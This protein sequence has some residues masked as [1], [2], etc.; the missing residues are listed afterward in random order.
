[1]IR[2]T[3]R[4]SRLERR[5]ASVGYAPSA[6]PRVNRGRGRGESREKA[7]S[8]HGRTYGVDAI[9]GAFRFRIHSACGSS[10]GVRDFR[11]SFR[12]VGIPR[13]N[14]ER[15]TTLVGEDEEKGTTTPKVRGRNADGRVGTYVAA[16]TCLSPCTYTLLLVTMCTSR[17]QVLPVLVSLFLP[18]SLS[19]PL[20]I[21]LSLSAGWC[22]TARRHERATT[23]SN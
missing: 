3:S 17:V 4:F 5:N 22:S 1:M 10:L 15:S 20:C 13:A 18:L 11:I 8:D 9:V 2:R 16:S 19:L 14:E 21:S 12:R 7:G 6:E 23:S